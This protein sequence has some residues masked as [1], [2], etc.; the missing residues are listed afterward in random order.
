MYSPRKF[1]IFAPSAEDK[2]LCAFERA[3]DLTPARGSSPLIFASPHSGHIYPPA[4]LATCR[5][6]QA[7]L[8]SVEDIY[9]DDLF[10]AAPG[11]GAA[12][13]GALFPRS[14]VDAN[15]AAD[16]LPAELAA[17]HA[18]ISARAKAGLGVIPLAISRGNNIYRKGPDPTR[19]AARIAAL[20]RPYHDA[21]RGLADRAIARAGRAIIIDC[22]SMPG[23]GPMNTRRADF[24]L[25]DRYGKSCAPQLINMI[26]D[27]LTARDYSV[28]R[29]HPYAGGY[30]TALY[31]D[32]G[33]GTSALQIE[34]NRDLY[35]N[36]VSLKPKSGYAKLKRDL[37]DMTA[38]VCARHDGQALAAE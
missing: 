36:P 26:A 16:D 1:R 28:S 18:V 20:H 30:T 27:F 32:P 24:I 11:F 7:A 3:Y 9:V 38:M 19:A 35:V 22:H 2:I 8:R 14:L 29:N 33:A 4:W 15:R 23:F 13:I 34:I 5:V 37:T 10:A 25:G 31:G 12:Y 6:T 21:L 17:P